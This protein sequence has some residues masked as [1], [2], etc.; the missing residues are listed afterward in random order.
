MVESTKETEVYNVNAPR[1]V[2]PH[3][4]NHFVIQHSQETQTTFQKKNL[5]WVISDNDV[6]FLS[7]NFGKM[8]LENKN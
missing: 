5:A 7:T 8:Y 1:T 6:F 4:T 3:T 2:H